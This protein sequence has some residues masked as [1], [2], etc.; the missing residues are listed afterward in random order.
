MAGARASA[1]IVM[2]LAIVLICAGTITVDACDE[3]NAVD[4]LS[5][6]V[7]NELRCAVGWQEM[8][9]RSELREG[10]GR[11]TYLKTLCRRVPPRG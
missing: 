2:F 9:A 3:A 11:T 6:R 4:V 1:S 7:V 5:T 10:L 8:I